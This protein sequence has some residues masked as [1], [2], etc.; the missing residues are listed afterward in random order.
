MNRA[1]SIVQCQD[2]TPICKKIARPTLGL[3]AQ[4]V[5]PLF[6]EVVDEHNDMKSLAYSELVPVTVRAIQELNEK[7]QNKNDES[8]A[9]IQKLEHRLK[10]L[11]AENADLRA[12]LERLEA[13]LDNRL[14]KSPK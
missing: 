14:S 10:R 8:G 11:D 2:V 5:E 4:E 7:V 3:I 13:L 12:R 1:P 9:K 6:P